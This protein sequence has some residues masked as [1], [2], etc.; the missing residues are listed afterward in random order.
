VYSSGEPL[1]ADPSKV[2]SGEPG[3]DTTKNQL[4]LNRLAM[5]HSSTSASPPHPKVTQDALACKLPDRNSQPS[6]EQGK[7]GRD[8]AAKHRK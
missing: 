2:S 8:E 3:F 6:E 4:N 7:M 5:S 1:K